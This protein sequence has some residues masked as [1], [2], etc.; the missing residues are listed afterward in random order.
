MAFSSAN[1]GSIVN[2]LDSMRHE[3]AELE[4]FVSTQL[5]LETSQLHRST[6]KALQDNEILHDQ[7]VRIVYFDDH[8]IDDG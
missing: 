4:N 1:L 8:S 7:L 6:G 2:S 3:F 5:L